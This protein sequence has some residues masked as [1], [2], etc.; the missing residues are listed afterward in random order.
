MPKK[1]DQ[2]CKNCE[3][4]CT[5][6][7]KTNKYYVRCESCRE[8][9]NNKIDCRKCHNYCTINPKTNKP[10]NYCDTCRKN[11][12]QIRLNKKLHKICVT[13][14]KKYDGKLVICN[15]CNDIRTQQRLQLNSK[16]ICVRCR[17]IS[18]INLKTNKPYTYC[19][20][21]RNLHKTKN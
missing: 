13:C 18:E 20:Q 15:S 14:H 16:G 6:N 1:N 5:I 10:Y 8:K 19:G 9:L 7:P 4:E 11:N 12:L 2:I 21:C 17:G 3:N